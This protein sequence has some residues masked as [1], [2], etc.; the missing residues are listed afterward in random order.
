M[1]RVLIVSYYFPPLGG[2]GSL[3][4][5]GFAQHLPEFGWEPIVLAPSNGAYFRDPSLTFPSDR[6]IRTRSLELSRTGKRLLAAGGDDVRPA[7]VGPSR[8]PARELARRWLYFPDAQI[9][10]YPGAVAAGRRLVRNSH[11]DAIFSSSPPVTAHLA[12]RALH[13][14]SGAPWIAEFRDPWSARIRARGLRRAER[15]EH[16]IATEASALVMPSP[17]WAAEHSRKWNRPVATIPNGYGYVPPAST[18]SA[19]PVACYLGSYEPR[20]QD[21]SSVWRA[22]A[23][24]AADRSSSPVRIRVIGEASPAMSAE[25][26]A[27]GVAGLWEATGFVAHEEALRHLASTSLLLAA[28][29]APL[30]GDLGKGWVQG[31][32]FEYLAT[33]LPII[34]VGTTPNDGASLLAAHE[35]CRIVEPGDVSTVVEAIKQQAGKHYRRDLAGLSRRD[36][37]KALAELLECVAQNRVP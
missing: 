4:T 32:L 9:G 27:C 8:A 16:S 3:R 10:W 33:G 15:M 2:I 30:E 26:R 6:V 31:K 1:R 7:T 22:I 18:P 11:F 36:R 20:R 19:R 12:A 37:T 23:R 29:P 34:W 14:S 24:V 21:L 35:G 5:L 17:S 28:G 25:L 13:R